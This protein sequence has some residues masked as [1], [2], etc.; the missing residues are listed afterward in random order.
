M[1]HFEYSVEVTVQPAVEPATLTDLANHVRNEVSNLNAESGTIAIQLVAA[2]QSVE[3]LTGRALITRTQRLNLSWLPP[4]ILMPDAPLIAVSSFAY[5]DSDGASQTLTENTDFIVDTASQPGRLKPAR[6]LSWP[7]LRD[8]IYNAAQIT[9]TAGYGAASTDVPAR[10]RQG[11]LIIAGHWYKFRE[12]IV[13]GAVASAIAKTFDML[14]EPLAI[15]SF[16]R[17]VA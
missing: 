16:G 14:I 8:G 2:R 17:R 12:P 15:Q 1:P 6:G 3:E 7:S 4:E 10:L 11:V 5:T 13:V 9:Y